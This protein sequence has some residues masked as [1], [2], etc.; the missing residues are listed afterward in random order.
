MGKD[1]KSDFR[2]KKGAHLIIEQRLR[3][4]N[5]EPIFKSRTAASD[6]DKTFKSFN[7]IIKKSGLPFNLDRED[8]NKSVKNKLK[9]RREQDK[10]KIKEYMNK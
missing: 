1:I 2:N 5:G 6:R 4:W 3:D 9:K 7:T 8:K 10:K